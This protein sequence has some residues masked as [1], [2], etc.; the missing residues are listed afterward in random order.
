MINIALRGVETFV[1]ITECGSFRRAAQLL[2]RSRSAV[3]GRV[4]KLENQL[5]RPPLSRTTR[6][7]SLTPAGRTQPIRNM[8]AVTSPGPG[9]TVM[10]R[11]GV[12][13][14]TFSRSIG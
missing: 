11:I 6:R 8:N 12:P 13:D 9:V 7:V 3:S 14:D 5:K 10:P 1:T 2:S 4:K